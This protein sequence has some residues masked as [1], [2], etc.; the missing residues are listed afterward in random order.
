MTTTQTDLCPA[1][2]SKQRCEHSL[3]LDVPLCDKGLLTALA[4]ILEIELQT[5]GTY[6]M[7]QAC[8]RRG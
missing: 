1:N 7:L 3:P 4:A 2:L 5:E 6:K 8:E